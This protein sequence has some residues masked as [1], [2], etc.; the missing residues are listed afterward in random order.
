MALSGYSVTLGSLASI[1]RRQSRTRL[2]VASPGKVLSRLIRPPA[3]RSAKATETSSPRRPKLSAASS[4]AGPAPTTS[5]FSGA[6]GAI[7]SGCQPLRHSSPIVGF[8]VQRR[9]TPSLLAARQML[10][11]IHSRISSARPSRILAG[12]K[13]S[14][15]EGRAAPMKSWIPPLIWATIRSG[16]VKRPTDT[17]GLPVSPLTKRM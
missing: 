5:T 12:R 7:R 3:C 13:G 4:P 16:E 8:C 1:V 9:L 14:A 6:W 15:I 11:P 10:Q 2:Q 17:T